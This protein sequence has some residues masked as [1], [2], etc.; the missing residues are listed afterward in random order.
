MDMG[1]EGGDD[2]YKDALRVVIESQGID[3]FVAATSAYWL[4][5]RRSYYRRNGK[6]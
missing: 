3:Q 2:M 5:P 4:C 1:S 6:A